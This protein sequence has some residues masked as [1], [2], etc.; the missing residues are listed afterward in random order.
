[1]KFSDFAQLFTKHPLY[2]D[3]QGALLEPKSKAL[4]KGINGSEPYFFIAQIFKDLRRNI[5]V[6]MPDADEAADA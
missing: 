4:W 6:V 3:L 2:F 1:M 5:V